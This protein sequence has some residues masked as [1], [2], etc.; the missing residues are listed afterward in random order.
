[1][2]KGRGNGEGSIY[3]TKDGSWRGAVM[4]GYTAEGKPKRKYV[5]GET[6]AEVRDKVAE[7]IAKQ[8]AGLPT[9]NERTTVRQFLALWL[10][11]ERSRIGT[12][13][14]L[15]NGSLV[16]GYRETTYRPA[17]WSH[18]TFPTASAGR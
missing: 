9:I 17:D 2:S 6:R 3:E 10:D 5:S 13:G 4:I 1:M 18:S 12:V 7:I 14:L 16:C 11:H 15:L 8:R